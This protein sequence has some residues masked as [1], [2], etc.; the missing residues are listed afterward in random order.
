MINSHVL[1]LLLPYNSVSAFAKIEHSIPI[2]NWQKTVSYGLLTA[3][4]PKL[5]FSLSLHAVKPKDEHQTPLAL[6]MAYLACAEG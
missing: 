6:L 2:P 1:G 3:G 5:L 4:E